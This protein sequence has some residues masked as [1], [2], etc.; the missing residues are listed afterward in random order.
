MNNT[1]PYLF[2]DGTYTW[3][4]WICSRGIGKILISRTI[5]FRK[6]GEPQ[7]VTPMPGDYQFPCLIED[8]N[9]GYRIF[10]QSRHSIWT[11]HSERGK[12]WS[13]PEQVFLDGIRS[14]SPR[15]DLMG[16]GVFLL[17]H[18]PTRIHY[19][20]LSG[21]LKDSIKWKVILPH[22]ETNGADECAQGSKTMQ[23]QGGA[24]VFPSEERAAVAY[25]LKRGGQWGIYFITGEIYE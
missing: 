15:A 6:W 17:F 13:E 23:A 25:A 8:R 22:Y 19:T 24:V 9:G 1:D 11:T 4:V 5:D 16:N 10:F 14:G 20:L 21:S 2:N 18:S 7:E 12:S 3:L